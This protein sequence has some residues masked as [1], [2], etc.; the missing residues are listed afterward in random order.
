[1]RVTLVVQF[2]S[3][4]ECS[5]SYLETARQ[6]GIHD[7]TNTHSDSRN[8]GPQLGTRYA[9]GCP[10]VTAGHIEDRYGLVTSIGTTELPSPERMHQVDWSL[11][12]LGL[13]PA[14]LEMCPFAFVLCSSR[15]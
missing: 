10:L 12:A 5:C 7:A 6:M 2:V 8:Q 4:D 9:I 3:A 15:W 11:G 1:M 13:T 14:Q